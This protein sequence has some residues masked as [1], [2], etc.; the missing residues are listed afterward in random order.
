M[1]LKTI[2]KNVKLLRTPYCDFSITDEEGN[3]VSFDIMESPEEE[4][5]VWLDDDE[6]QA[7]PV[8]FGEGKT[9]RLYT[10][11]LD[12][13]RNYYIRPS[14]KL[15]ARD[16]DERLFTHGLTGEDYTFAV[17]FPDPNE[18]EKFELDCTEDDY[19]FYN[20]ECDDEVYILRLYDRDIEYIDIFMFWIWN[21]QDHMPDY[22]SACDIATWWCP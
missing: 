19:H 22:E 11:N 1:K 14:V 16:S 13:K 20:I 9:L 2:E 3:A 6:N 21:I 18:M 5:Q 12:I 17:S 10:K 8:K 15:I 4:T 7:I